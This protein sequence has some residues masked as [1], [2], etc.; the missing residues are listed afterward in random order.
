MLGAYNFR[1]VVTRG[2]TRPP[3]VFRS[4]LLMLTTA[5]ARSR[6]AAA[7]VTL[8]IDLRSPAAA[9]AFP[10]RPVPGAAHV[11]IDVI[12][13]DDVRDLVGADL[14]AARYRQM[15]AHEGQRERVTAVLTAVADHDGGVLVHCTDGKDRTGW[16]AALL[17]HIGGDDARAVQEAYLASGRA[18]RGMVAA[19][20][21]G[22]LLRRG[23]AYARSRHPVNVVRAAYLESAL[24]EVTARFGDLDGY[25]RDGLGLDE[26]TL[27]RLRDRVA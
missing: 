22:D 15:V 23:P 5:Y 12:G 8:V 14:M 3:V 17:Q 9:A 1:P 18:V 25:L 27:N 2:R 24:A 10:D 19:R 6:M 21:V 20:Y 26:A 13:A 11:N 7:G 4:G 16:I